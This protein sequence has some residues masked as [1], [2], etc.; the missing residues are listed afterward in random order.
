MDK[1][2]LSQQI[3]AEASRLGFSACGIA[4]AKDVGDSKIYLQQWLADGNHAG[5]DY[6]ANNFEKRCSPSLLVEGTKSI[7]CL[8]LNYYPS[9]RLRKDQPQFA[10]YA[11]GK[12]Y[13]EVMKA[14]LTELFSF[15]ATLLPVNGRVFCDTAPILERFWAQQ[16]GL[17]W[18]GKNS[19]LIIPKAGSYFFLGELFLDIDLDYDKPIK[20]RCGK[21]SLCLDSCP[22]KALYKPYLLDSKRCLSYLTIENKGEIE[23]EY[24]SKIGNHIYGCDDCQNCCPWNRFAKPHSVSEFK[25]SD[26][27]LSME[28]DDW[29]QLT[30]E[31]YRTLFKGS[32]VKRAKYDGLIRNIKAIR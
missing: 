22:T 10:F 19:Q 27:F 9:K 20:N 15:I 23:D 17:G 8:A 5:M 25:P 11:Y 31:Q 16:A 12:D 24:L 26:Y 28:K 29:S 3:K 14:K 18:I 7:V 32:A 13:H 21:C 6:M 4:S 1:R 30:I 2:N